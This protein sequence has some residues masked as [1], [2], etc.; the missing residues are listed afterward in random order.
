MTS[1]PP[2][3]SCCRPNSIRPSTDVSVVG[4]RP[5]DVEP[6]GRGLEHLSDGLAPDLVRHLREPH[7]DLA[8]AGI[9]DCIDALLLARP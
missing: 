4:I 7:P 8:E 6:F 1:S 3:S 2:R 5:A 9:K